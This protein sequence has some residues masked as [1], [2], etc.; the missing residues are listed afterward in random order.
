MRRH[1]LLLMV[2]TSVPLAPALALPAA[3]AA[4]AAAS[5]SA[6]TANTPSN[7]PAQPATSPLKLLPNAVVVDTRIDPVTQQPRA[8]SSL[9][10]LVFLRKEYLRQQQRLNELDQSHRQGLALNQSLQLDNDNLSVQVKVLQGD[11]SAQMFIYGALTM[12]V[13]MVA[14]YL[15]SARLLSARRRW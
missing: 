6:T 12:L 15:I 7:A 9:D 5:P 3:V 13:G 4:P 1:A 10:Q 2:L 11:R 14:G 8:L